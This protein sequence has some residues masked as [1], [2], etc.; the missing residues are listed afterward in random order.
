MLNILEKYLWDNFGL[1]ERR[2]IPF[3][4]EIIDQMFDLGMISNKK[5]AYRTLEK[6]S[7]K[8]LYVWGCSISF[9][10]K[11]TEELKDGTSTASRRTE[12]RAAQESGKE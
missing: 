7:S 10:W 11:T 1:D 8:G 5:Q 6:W 2:Q 4:K 3:A 12:Q 9:G